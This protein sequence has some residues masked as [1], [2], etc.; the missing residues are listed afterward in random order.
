MEIKSYK[1]LAPVKFPELKARQNFL[2]TQPDDKGFA[3]DQIDKIIQGIYFRK[4][5]KLKPWEKDFYNNIYQ[6]SGKSNHQILRN[7]KTKIQYSKTINVEDFS[8]NNYYKDS[9]LR[10]INNS[11]EIAKQ[12]LSNVRIRRKFRQPATNIKTYTIETKKICKN[13]MLSDIIKYERSKMRKK[14]NEY[15]NAL[16]KEINDLE[17]DIYNFE[18]YATNEMFKKNQKFKYMNKIESKTKNLNQELKNLIQES[19]SLQNEIPKT[20]KLINE[21]KIYVNFVH[22]LFGGEPELGD[23]N[24]DELN[25]QNMSENELHS[26][27]NMIENEMKKSKPEDSVLITSTDEELLGNINKIDIVFKF[28]EDNILQTLEKNEKLRYEIVS[29]IEEGEKEKEELKKKIEEREN[30]YIALL[31]EYKVEKENLQLIYSS[32]EEYNNYIRKLHIELFE[33]VNDVLVKKNDIDEYN[34]IDKIIKPNI[35]DIKEK[36]RQIDSLEIEMQKYSKEDHEIFNNSL[37]KI[38]NE[39]KLLKFHKEKIKRENTNSL[40]NEKILQKINKIMFTGRNK[41]KMSIP[42][43]LIKK[44]RNNSKKIETEPSDFKLLYY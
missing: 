21:K 27:T 24:L 9:Q 17:K 44:R 25:F 14:L 34:I 39:N 30:E 42:L 33:C 32:K 43:N 19:R 16:K 36:E 8:N 6:S 11:Q 38:K 40:R 3:Q 10:T 15:E 31:E 26:V 1:I 7:I 20:L 23:C 22:K 2:I 28:M 35:K 37:T 4:Q 18:Q 41:Y 29:I 12:V 13:N 5:K